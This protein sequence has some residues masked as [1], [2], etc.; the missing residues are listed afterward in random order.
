MRRQ[1]LRKIIV[2]LHLLEKL[3]E[4][5]DFLDNLRQWHQWVDFTILITDGYPP[6][7][8]TE[9]LFPWLRVSFF[10]YLFSFTLPSDMAWRDLPCF[11]CT[12]PMDEGWHA[13]RLRVKVSGEWS[14]QTSLIKNNQKNCCTTVCIICHFG[15]AAVI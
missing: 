15:N 14:R 4:G 3:S 2:V 12:S 13:W 5:K 1:A 8:Y 6:V 10:P 11:W 9:V 7:G